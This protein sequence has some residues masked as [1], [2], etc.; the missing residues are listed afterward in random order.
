MRSLL[1]FF[2]RSF[3]KCAAKLTL[4]LHRPRVIALAGSTNKSFVKDEV[5]TVLRNA[6]FSVRATLRNFNT[7]VGLPLSILGLSSGYGDY[8]AWLPVLFQSI[9]SVFC[10]SFPNVLILEFG[11]SNRGDMRYL[12]SI[13]HPDIVVLTGVTQRYMEHFSDI[14]AMMKEYGLLVR[15]MKRDGLLVFN[16]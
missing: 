2:L 6:P 15:S 3:L 8:R 9:R 13:V 12:L 14:N 7:G 11:V 1:K 4:F 5:Q 10:R 16:G